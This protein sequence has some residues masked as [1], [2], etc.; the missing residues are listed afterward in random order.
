MLTHAVAILGL[1]LGLM[2]WVYLRGWMAAREP[3]IPD[4]E[5]RCGTCARALE[6]NCCGGKGT[7][8]TH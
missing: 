4:F 6:G 2:G 1:G 8:P 5:K 7:G 3:E